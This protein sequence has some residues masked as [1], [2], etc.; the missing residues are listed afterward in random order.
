MAGTQGSVSER[1][2]ARKKRIVWDDGMAVRLVRL[3]RLVEDGL[4]LPRGTDSGYLAKVSV[5]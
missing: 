1:R 2:M 3:V 4:I 5:L